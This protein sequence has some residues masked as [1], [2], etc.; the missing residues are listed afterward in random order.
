MP[1][2]IAVILGSAFGKQHPEELKLTRHEIE[3]PWGMQLVFQTDRTDHPAYLI[4]RHGIPHRLLPNQINYR[5][6][7]WAL[8]HLQCAGLL[9]TSSVGVLD[10]NLPL[11]RPMFLTDLLMPENRLPDGTACTM[12]TSPIKGQ[13]HLVL[14]EGL[15]SRELTGQVYGLNEKLTEKPDREIVFVYAGGPR[16][17]TKAENQMWFQL[18][19]HVNSMTLAP[20]IIL[21]NELEIPSTGI[22]TGHKY[23]VAGLENPEDTKAV[24]DS[25]E[26]SRKALEKVII[27]FLK[28]G[29]P[30]PFT[31]HLY[32]FD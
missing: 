23:S 6:Q 8:K 29:E 18:G 15:F 7:A 28:H 3:T 11:Y 24:S 20:E 19:G 31:N 30:V 22:V 10:R 12:F 32:R 25:L 26:D 17:K 9:V 5:A 14:T 2:S 21:A 1:S 16:G 13:G 27:N 4:F